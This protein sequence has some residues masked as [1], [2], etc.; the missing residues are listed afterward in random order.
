MQ[1][2]GNGGSISLQGISTIN[3]GDTPRFTITPNTGY[4][5]DSIIVNGNK[6]ANVNNYIFDSVKSN[7]TI[8]VVFKLQTYT[9]TSIAGNGGSISPQ[10]VSN[11]N[12]GATPIYTITPNYRLFNR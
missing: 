11:V 12:Y 2:A 6:V 7:Q 1:N 9:I 4:F 10:G 5:I 8:R 3:Y